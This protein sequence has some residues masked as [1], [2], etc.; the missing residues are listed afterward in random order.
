MIIY[1]ET[2]GG[3]CPLQA[4]GKID[5]VPFYFRARGQHWSM[6]IG[7]DPVMASEWYAECSWGRE[8][9]AAGW[10]PE[11]EARRLIEWCASEYVRNRASASV[12]PVL[13]PADVSDRANQERLPEPS[14]EGE[15]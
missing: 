7:G 6:G 11:E 5:G 2:I 15:A 8:K 12:E 14:L 1:I 10:M 13:S 9:F 4:E 3:N